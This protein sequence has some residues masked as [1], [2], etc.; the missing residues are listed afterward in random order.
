MLAALRA[1]GVEDFDALKEP[2]AYPDFQ[3]QDFGV[4]QPV[5]PPVF[6]LLL[7]SVARA[8]ASSYRKYKHDLMRVAEINEY[9]RK[10][11]EVRKSAALGSVLMQQA[12]IDAFHKDYLGG[13]K[14]AIELYSSIVLSLLSRDETQQAF[15][16]EY[17]PETKTLLIEYRLQPGLNRDELVTAVLKILDSIFESDLVHIDVVAFNG[18]VKVHNPQTG[19]KKPAWLI[20]LRI[21][22]SDNAHLKISSAKHI[23][24]LGMGAVISEAP[25]LPLAIE[26]L[27]QF[28]LALKQAVRWR[29]ISAATDSRPYVRD[30][31]ATEYYVMADA[32]MK[33]LGFV[34]EIID[35]NY[36]GRSRNSSRLKRDRKEVIG[37]ECLEYLLKSFGIVVRSKFARL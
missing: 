4:R 23:D 3:L 12:E 36:G 1:G 20:S 33:D 15:L 17:L 5:R 31:T 29:D 2:F 13:N 34:T 26:P 32:L 10:G 30:L 7:P 28:S 27:L 25:E 18:Y 24:L 8:Y 22:R 19:A 9:N 6:Q 14:R 37:G 21:A 16:L 11:Y 35:V